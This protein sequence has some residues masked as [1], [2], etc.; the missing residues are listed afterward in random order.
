MIIDYEQ[1]LQQCT[2]G[3]HPQI[4]HGI[5]RQ[6]SSFNP[7]AIGVVNGRLSRQP[8]NQA[9]AVATVRTLQA[10]GMNYSMGLAQVNKQHMRRFG[11]TAESIFE[12]CA[13]VRAGATI[14]QQCHNMAKA[15]FGN[16]AYAI[17]A[18][19]SC[20]YSGNFTTG[21]RR[22]GRD[23][24]PYVDSVRQQMLTYNQRPKQIGTVKLAQTALRIQVPASQYAAPPAPTTPVIATP[25]FAVNTVEATPL[26]PTEANQSSFLING[27][28]Q[29]R[30]PTLAENNK[31]TS[32]LLF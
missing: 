22:Y 29:N 13:N 14:F 20:Y 12:P 17:S 15:R 23:K 31:P 10:R 32:S 1:L 19:L 24:A 28:N 27:G 18:A 6:E 30:N 2:N 5:I 8:E 7:Y 25:S 9:E 4:M 3:V 11:F 21:F 26:Q 16:T